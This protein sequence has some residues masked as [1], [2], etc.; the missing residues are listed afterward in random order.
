MKNFLLNCVFWFLFIGAML[1]ACKTSQTT[2][3][4]YVGEWHY[5]IDWE[6]TEY[7]MKMIINTSD[8]GYS[9]MFSSEWGDLP[10]DDLV[11]EDDKLTAN[12][13][14]QGNYVD[15]EGTFEGD[16]FKGVSS[17]GGYE[18]PMEATRKIE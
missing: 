16:T 12:Y 5:T 7:P 2:A 13:D 11:I 14:F 17:S 3:S 9:G 8:D 1:T 4:R 18:F 15:F 10:L 6:G